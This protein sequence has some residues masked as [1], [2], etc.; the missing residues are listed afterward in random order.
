MQKITTNRK[1]FKLVSPIDR[2][3]EISMG[4]EE[5]DVYNEIGTCKICPYYLDT[6]RMRR[7]NKDDWEEI[8][9]TEVR[10]CSKKYF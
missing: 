3:E 2:L 6:I 1:L 7:V 10:H 9:G 4:K 8:P 5:C